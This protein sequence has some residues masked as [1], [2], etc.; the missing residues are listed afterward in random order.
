[1]GFHIV[2]G[3]IIIKFFLGDKNPENAIKAYHRYIKGFS[4]HPFWS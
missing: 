1:M 4:I 3:N 2:G